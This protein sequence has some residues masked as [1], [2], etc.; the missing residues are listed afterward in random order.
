MHRLS[1]E[2]YKAR[3]EKGLTQEELADLSGINLRTIQRIENNQTNPRGNTLKLIGKVLSEDFTKSAAGENKVIVGERLANWVFIVILNLLM[4]GVIGFLTLD[5]NA[6]L[7]SRFG[8][9]L[10]SFLLPF[11]IVLFTESMSPIERLLKFGSGL[12]IYSLSIQI[13]H[14]FPLGF[15][16]GLFPCTLITL[17]ILYFGSRLL[18]IKSFVSN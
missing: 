10:L 1:D 16:S 15:L 13:M 18:N 14:G 11:I 8:A 7:N 17:T 4:M 9:A 2:I 12:L 6:N 3:K 5:S